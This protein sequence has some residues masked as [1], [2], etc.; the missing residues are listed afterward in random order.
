MPF[1]LEPEGA[2]RFAEGL[3]TIVVVEEKRAL[4]E[5]QLK[6]VL[7]A[8]P[9]APRI[10]GKRDED[11][12]PLFPSAGRLD[13]NP[14]AVEI[15][16]RLLAR[17]GD[18]DGDGGAA[19]AKA[20]AWNKPVSRPPAALDG[21]P[22]GWRSITG[23]SWT[24]CSGRSARPPGVTVIV[25]DQTCAAEKRRRRKRGK[26]PDPPRRAFIN[27][28][29]CEGCGDCGVKSNSE[30]AASFGFLSHWTRSPVPIQWAGRLK[31]LAH[32]PPPSKPEAHPR[33]AF[34][35]GRRRPPPVF[36]WASRRAAN[37]GGRGG[38]A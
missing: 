17:V 3:D 31:R 6:D 5:T 38:G 7:Y 12:R 23:V 26:L 27:P 8:A 33:C 21:A 18:S 2:R 1:P 14:I 9:D 13:T 10:A 22:A 29:V 15:G 19:G 34:P 4:I 25:Y 20:P 35:P 11:G 36:G 24:R 16:R 30:A 28:A 37:L 32:E